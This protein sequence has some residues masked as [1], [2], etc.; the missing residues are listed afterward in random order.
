MN[1]I[2]YDFETNGLDGLFIVSSHNLPYLFSISESV[3]VRFLDLNNRRIEQFSKQTSNHLFLT[4]ERINIEQYNT[5]NKSIFLDTF[6]T[7]NMLI[8]NKEITIEEVY[9]IIKNIFTNINLIKK[10]LKELSEPYIGDGIYDPLYNDFKRLY[11][12]FSSHKLQIHE[13]ANKY[14]E[15]IQVFTTE[16]KLCEFY[17]EKCN[18]YPYQKVKFN[19]RPLI[20]ILD[21]I[22]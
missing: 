4:K 1:K 8:C 20:S 14:Y 10:K 17:N 13:G 5:Y 2:F 3:P 11:M 22:P 6:Y 21:T 18:V 12:I 7:K 15:E 9:N 16:D 19:K